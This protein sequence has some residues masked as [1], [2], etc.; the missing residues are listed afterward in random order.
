MLPNQVGANLNFQFCGPPAVSSGGSLPYVETNM[1]QTTRVISH[2][3][4]KQIFHQLISCDTS[5]PISSPLLPRA[6]SLPCGRN[7]PTYWLL[8]W[9]IHHNLENIT[10]TLVLPS[11]M[12]PPKTLLSFLSGQ[13]LWG[14]EEDNH[15][16]IHY[17]LEL[18][19]VLHWLLALRTGH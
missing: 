12:E 5:Y 6:A 10:P 15:T 7:G 13:L 4:K 8:I 19:A 2:K 9:G 16:Y 18:I 17:E 11:I 3:Y 14:D 1:P